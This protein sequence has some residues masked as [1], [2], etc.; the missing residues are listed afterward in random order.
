MEARKM[1]F[2]VEI[3]EDVFWDLCG[4]GEDCEECPY[5]CSTRIGKPWKEMDLL[6]QAKMLKRMADK[7]VDGKG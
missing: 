1:N 5:Q 2:V 7:I 4:L 6:E 3:L